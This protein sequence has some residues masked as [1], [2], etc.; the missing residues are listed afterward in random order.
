MKFLRQ[1]SD[2]FKQKSL[3]DLIPD[4]TEDALDLMKKCLTYDPAERLTALEILKHPFFNDLYDDND[5]ELLIGDPI[6]Y[7]DFEFENY[8]L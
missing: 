8:T 7:Y 4:A 6:K 2:E 3:K 5:N 1:H